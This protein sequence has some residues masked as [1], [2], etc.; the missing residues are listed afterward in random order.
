MEYLR[1]LSMSI[2]LGSSAESR[3]LSRTNS[4]ETNISEDS[5]NL[6]FKTANSD[7]V[8]DIESLEGTERSSTGQQFHQENVGTGRP[9]YDVGRGYCLII[10]QKN[11]PDGP[12]TGTNYDA[13]LLEYTFQKLNFEVKIEE[14]LTAYGMKKALKECCNHLNQNSKTYHIMCI[15]FLSHGDIDKARRYDLIYGVDQ[16]GV[17]IID[18]IVSDIFNCKNCPAMST[19]PK[20]F[21]SNACRGRKELSGIMVRMLYYVL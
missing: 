15:C 20:L 7:F 4:Q 16:I 3:K 10:N 17:H 8:I 21:I 2:L 19:K 14:N 6:S 13:K 9:K 11:F 18:D 1:Q 5:S 12:R